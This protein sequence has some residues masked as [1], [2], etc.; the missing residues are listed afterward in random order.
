MNS[1]EDRLRGAYGEAAQTVAPEDVRA[2]DIPPA[3]RSRLAVRRHRVQW[4]APLAAAAAVTA[5]IITVVIASAPGGSPG[6]GGG[7]GPA[8][9]AGSS[10]PAPP[11]FMGTVS[12]PA[13]TYL[14]IYDARTGKI[15]DLLPPRKGFYFAGAAAVGSSRA[16]IVAA[17]SRKDRCDTLLYRLVVTARGRA[18]S[19]SSLAVG[20]VR[21]NLL[22]P[23]TSLAASANG[24]VIA[25]S[26]NACG[27]GHGWVSVIHL[28]TRQ[29]RTWP[30][31][32]EGLISLSM[33]ASGRTLDFID[34]SVYGGDDTVRSLATD[35]PVGP[36]RQRARIVLPASSGVGSTGSAV[37]AGRGATL[38]AC[39]ET[40][41][42]AI[43]ARY[44]AV[45]GQEIGVVHVWHQVDVAPC[46]VTVTPSGSDALVAN[47]VQNAIGTRIRLATDRARLEPGG[48]PHGSNAPIGIAW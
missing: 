45:T 3:R 7:P 27:G 10:A 20:R 26:A 5:I 39:H 21:G 47:V 11:F 16:F 19:I 32:T 30:L 22:S 18:A 12:R 33:S 40:G 6:P 24:Q 46:V 4:L 25:Y 9:A 48:G 29:V 37:L 14:A 41:H 13:G 8:P 23:S 35:A 15:T 34:T 2:F 44:N 17:S 42:D 28:A 31:D 1:L 36:I 38:L 43:L